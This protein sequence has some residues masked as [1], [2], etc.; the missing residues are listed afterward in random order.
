MDSSSI[1]KWL[2]IAGAGLV[3]AGAILWLAGRL[4]LPMGNLPG[5]I[6]VDHGR[7]SFRFPLVTCII[8]SIV[9]TVIMNI[10]LHRFR[11]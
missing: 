5:D 2:V 1:G 6:K 3:V 4:G 9:L 8:L 11:G 10:V 7:V